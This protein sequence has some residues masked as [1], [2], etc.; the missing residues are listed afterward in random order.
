MKNLIILSFFISLLSCNKPNEM[1]QQPN[2]Y[3]LDALFEFSVV[4]TQ[5]QDLLDPSSP[6]HINQ[7]DIKLYYLIDG[8]SKQVYNQNM[9]NPRNF[10]I[11]K[12]EN[13]YRIRIFP[14]ISET[15][16]KTTTYIQWNAN[17]T[18]TLEVLYERTPRALLERKVWINGKQIWDWTENKNR[19]SI[20]VK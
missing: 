20:L 1:N 15:E 13:E 4:N 16:D 19:F 11:Y 3:N 5:N 18:D 10:L 8:H 2:A 14:N 12:H 17:D 7:S 6:N 9:D